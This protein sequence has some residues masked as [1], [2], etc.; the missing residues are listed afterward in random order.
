MR[1]RR[2]DCDPDDIFPASPVALDSLL[3][4]FVEG[5]ASKIVLVPARR[6]RSWDEELRAL[7]SV[8]FVRRASHETAVARR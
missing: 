4:A 3:A 5:G 2:P 1:W 6:P 7:A 8:D